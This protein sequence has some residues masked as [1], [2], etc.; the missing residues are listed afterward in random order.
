MGPVSARLFARRDQHVLRSCDARHQFLHQAELGGI[1]EVVGRV[2]G[3]D[4]RRDSPE[5]RRRIVLPRCL[6]GVQHVVGI[7]R[8]QAALHLA[9][10]ELVGLV[11]RRSRPVPLDRAARHQHQDVDCGLEP[12]RLGCVV[13]VVPVR[14][15]ADI[16]DNHL[17]HD[18][19]ATGDR[20]RHARKRDEAIHEVRI[21]LSPDPRVHAAHRRA[22]DNAEVVHLQPLGQE[23]VLRCHHVLV[24]VARKARAQIRRS[25]CSTGRA[26][27]HPAG[28]RSAWPRRTAGRGR[29]ARPRSSPT[30]TRARS[31]PSHGG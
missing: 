2:D 4:R 11:T 23:P 7:R 8:R 1:H 16:I 27:F 10:E 29:T 20:G 6:E 19:V 24:R 15:P 30:G 22:H 18:T 21:G 26:R 12:A 13:A 14:V 31:R 9:G 28:S 5:K 3:Q 17:P 25:V